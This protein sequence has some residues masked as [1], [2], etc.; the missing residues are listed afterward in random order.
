MRTISLRKILITLFLF[1]VYLIVSSLWG[2][3]WGIH[4]PHKLVSTIDP[5]F[6][7][8]KYEEV[9]F[10]TTD[11]LR[12]RG[13]FIPSKYPK[14]KTLILLHGYP[15]D[16]GNILPALYYL[17]NK[18]HLLFIDFRS[19]GESAGA[20]TT[21]GKEEV[22]DLLAAIDFLKTRGID[23]VGVYGFSMGGAVAMMA[24]AKSPAI[25]AIVADSSYARL[26][27]MLREYYSIPLAKYLLA[28]FT[29]LW[30]WIFLAT[31]PKEV[32][33]L[34]AIKQLKIPILIIHSKNDNIIPFSQ[35]I[36]LKDAAKNNPNVSYIFLEKNLHGDTVNATQ[37]MVERFFDS[38]L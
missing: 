15:A 18:Y 31:D 23:S 34:D 5:S 20:Y 25:K 12:I 4:P 38:N 3:Y 26:D 37:Q 19:F 32:S 17:N 9:E 8:I 36:L 24:A 13:W 6:F 28:E 1:G 22:L 29:R 16:K 30:S 14:A 33:P 11:N 7:G 27:L 2:F 21:I 10:K 35:A